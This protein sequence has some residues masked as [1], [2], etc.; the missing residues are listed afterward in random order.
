MPLFVIL[1][2]FTI[3]LSGAAVWSSWLW[4][5]DM[6]FYFLLFLTKSTCLLGLD[7]ASSYFY[8]DTNVRFSCVSVKSVVSSNTIIV[9][10]SKSIKPLL[11]SGTAHSSSAS[12]WFPVRVNK[13]FWGFYLP[14]G[15]CGVIRWESLWGKALNRMTCNRIFFDVLAHT[16][17]VKTVRLI[18]DKKIVKF[19]WHG[20]KQVVFNNNQA[21]V[22]FNWRRL[23]RYH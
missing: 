23:W 21:S 17:N 18:S 7:L 10:L 1:C 9:L 5:P 13:V 19:N 8:C 12:E 16:Y 15:M 14:R 20:E 3:E 6:H 11:L 2:R 22:C 4:R